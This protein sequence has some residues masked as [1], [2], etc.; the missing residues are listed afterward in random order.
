MK[1]ITIALT[2]IAGPVMA[3]QAKDYLAPCQAGDQEACLTGAQLAQA[4]KQNSLLIKLTDQGCALG[5]VIS[6]SDRGMFYLVGIGPKNTAK[7]VPLVQQGCKDGY[8]RACTNLGWV[9]YTGQGVQRDP[10][11]AA[12]Y[13]KIGCDGGSGS[14][15]TNL[16]L[17]YRDGDGVKQSTS[18]AHRLF[19]RA[20]DLGDQRGC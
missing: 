6:C 20:C 16:G 4:A 8:F 13:Y 17:M 10:A 11:K 2:L 15:C 7:G 12:G 5:N 1:W 18:K 19:D 14:A 3:N 9:L